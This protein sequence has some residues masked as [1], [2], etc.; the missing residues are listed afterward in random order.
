MLKKLQ[1]NK[2]GFSH[3]FLLPVIAVLAVGS[4]GA[5]LQFS[6]KAATA[7]PSGTTYQK[8]VGG[9]DI[10]RY[11]D[12]VGLHKGFDYC[13]SKLGSTGYAYK[14]VSDHMGDYYYLCERV[15]T[16]PCPSGFDF[17]M[18]AAPY[19]GSST[20]DLYW[21]T[22]MGVFSSGGGT[23]GGGTGGGSGGP[24]SKSCNPHTSVRSGSRGGCVAHAQDLLNQAGFGRL[25]VDGVYGSATKAA[26][27]NLEKKYGLTQNGEIT[28]TDWARLHDAVKGGSSTP[29]PVSKECKTHS[30]VKSGSKGGC[31]AHAQDLLN[32]ANFGNLK[33]DGVYGSSTKTAINKLEATYGL[34]QNGEITATDW[35]RLHKAS[36]GADYLNIH[37]KAYA[38]RTPRPTLNPGVTH[39]CV[40]YV[41]F[42]LYRAGIG[43][44]ELS[45]TDYYNP[46]TQT[47][48]KKFQEKYGLTVDGVIGSATWSKIDALAVNKERK[49]GEK[50]INIHAA[51][52]KCSYPMPTLNPSV[53]HDC[54]S[55]LQFSLY[56]ANIGA[57][58][59]SRTDYYNPTT[60]TYVKKFQEK[61]G[62][63]V[64]GVVG[65]KTWEKIN[66]LPVNQQQL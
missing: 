46:T 47:Y 57:P 25:S 49:E 30:S 15:P 24:V 64:D 40:S 34:T 20:Y 35:D 53:T 12:R 50:Y 38:C 14:S 29:P 33:V 28:A 58:E 37:D 63:T 16:G 43:A 51:A 10:C 9:A 7:C 6:S 13:Q 11:P 17:G 18:G 61:N 22:C 23:G 32:K 56:R 65:P 2:R 26:I 44:P 36:N 60:Q 8:G 3:H 48:V 4:I 42:S 54:V 27:N 45:R 59:L 62:L 21:W 66:A 5:Y 1:K 55:Y 52:Y 39:D 19:Q 31:V 41:Q